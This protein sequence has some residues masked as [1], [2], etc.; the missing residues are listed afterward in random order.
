V[1]SRDY[2]WTSSA[3]RRRERRERRTVASRDFG[4]GVSA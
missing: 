1:Y 3:R 4:E 2:T